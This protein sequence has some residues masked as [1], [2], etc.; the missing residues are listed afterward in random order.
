MVAVSRIATWA[1]FSQVVI[2]IKLP[3]PKAAL[4]AVWITSDG[5][6]V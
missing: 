3:A 6:D 4:V 5:I 2:E 1:S